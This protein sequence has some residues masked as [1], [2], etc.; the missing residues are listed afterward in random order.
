[1]QVFFNVQ[2]QQLG[3]TLINYYYCL[4][5]GLEASLKLSYKLELNFSSRPR[6]EPGQV[7][8][9]AQAI[10][11]ANSA[12]VAKALYI[13]KCYWRVLHLTDHNYKVRMIGVMQLY[14]KIY[15]LC[16]I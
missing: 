12:T 1:M 5:G 10:A 4:N 15:L 2:L 11:I 9:L 7:H 14:L 13:L 8:T 3:Y 6:L 16:T